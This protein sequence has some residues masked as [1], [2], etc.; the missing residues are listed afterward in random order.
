MG[1]EI[2][3]RSPKEPLVSY[4]HNNREMPASEF[5]PGGF[6]KRYLASHY[7]VGDEAFELFWFDL[8]Q[9]LKR[10]QDSGRIRS[11]KELILEDGPFVYRCAPP[12]RQSFFRSLTRFRN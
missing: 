7:A 10:L 2:Q 3:N 9:A 5:E 6:I 8:D 12:L 4:C 11:N 1:S